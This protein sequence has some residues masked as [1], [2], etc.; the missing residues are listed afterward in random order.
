[1]PPEL[2]D[3]AAICAR[4]AAFDSATIS[5][6]VET[7]GVQPRTAGYASMDVRCQFPELPPMAGYAVTC[8]HR[9]ASECGRKTEIEDLLDLV[10]AAEKPVVVVVQFVGSEPLRHCVVGDIVSVALQRLGAV[11]LVTD[12]GCRDLAGI[13][14]RAPG[15]QVLARGSIASHGDG[16]ICD[17][18]SEVEIGGLNVKTGSLIHGDANGLVLVPDGLAEETAE[19]AEGVVKTEASLFELLGQEPFDFDAVKARFASRAAHG[20]ATT[21][22]P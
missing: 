21:V 11:G 17:V 4:L 14:R 20:D 3:S 10:D 2:T 19:A 13:R 16:I 15:F 12:S 7:L 8:T 22:P 1:M 18:G 6:A 5:N 9:S